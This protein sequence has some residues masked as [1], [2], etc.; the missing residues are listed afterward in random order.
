MAFKVGPVF[1][2]KFF[3]IESLLFKEDEVRMATH[4]VPYGLI[5]CEG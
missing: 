4:E 1:Y 3:M 2:G 5:I